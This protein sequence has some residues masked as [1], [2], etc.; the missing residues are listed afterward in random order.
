MTDSGVHQSDGLK[1]GAPKGGNSF[2]VFVFFSEICS[3]L[4]PGVC[5]GNDDACC[6]TLEVSESWM[7]GSLASTILSIILIAL[8]VFVCPAWCQNQIVMCRELTEWLLCRTGSAAP[9][10]QLP[11]KLLGVLDSASDVQFRSWE[12]IVPRSLKESAVATVVTS[13][14]MKSSEEGLLRKSSPWSWVVVQL[15]VVLTT[16]E[17]AGRSPVCIQTLHCLRPGQ[18]PLY[19]QQKSGVWWVPPSAAIEG[20]M[21]GRAHMLGWRHT[22][23]PGVGCDLPKLHPLP[24]ICHDVWQMEPG[25][26]FDIGL[27]GW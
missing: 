19:Y 5:R 2:C 26:V 18:W 13:M 9:E 23:S 8:S 3:R 4:C 14:V 24:P 10:V 17:T 20:R 27:L 21:L 16:P 11:Q 1:E 25:T 7:Q 15:S 22:D 12:I 6:L